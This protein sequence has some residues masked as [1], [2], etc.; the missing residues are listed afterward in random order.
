MSAASL[1]E[2]GLP[3][4]YPFRPDWEVSPRQAQ[5]EL[6]SAAP[7]ILLDVRRDDE[8]DL[9]R[10]PGA[11]HIP[12]DQIERRADELED[13]DG[14]R[15]RPVII[16]CHHGRRSLRAAAALQALG[17]A[18]VRSLAGGIDLWSQA[19]DAGVRRY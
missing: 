17:F 15:D 2:H 4:G 16:Y 19:V 18:N 11:V 7:P 1:D 14:R 12:L 13:D 6:R 9:V 8:W 3:R 10:L 5:E